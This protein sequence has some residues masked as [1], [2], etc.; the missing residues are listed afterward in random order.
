MTPFGGSPAGLPVA[1]WYPD[2]GD[3][4][5]Q[6]WWD[7]TAWGHATRPAGL[8]QPGSPL[9]A[10]S[11]PHGPPALPPVERATDPL[12]RSQKVLVV[13]MT[14]AVVVAVVG[15]VGVVR[16]GFSAL[17]ADPQESPT[18]IQRTLDA[19]RYTVFDRSGSRRQTGPITFTEQGL[20]S[21]GPEDVTVTGPDGEL[22]AVT[23]PTVSETIDQGGAIYL[24]IARF[25]VTEPGTHRIDIGGAPSEV[26]V[27]RTLFDGIGGPLVLT[28]SGAV[29]GGLC[30]TTLFVIVL[31]KASRRRRLR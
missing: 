4:Q 2:P 10:P 24:G 26:I 17:G 28:A 13:V 11:P 5:L 9:L 16:T 22:L 15:I 7:G 14:I 25:T 3:P 29:I 20:T 23:W 8:P 30:A 31:V 6:R 18:T 27:S 21:I 1:G 12:W 19:G